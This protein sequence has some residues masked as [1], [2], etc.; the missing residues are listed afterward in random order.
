MATYSSVLVWRIQ[1][2]E[3]PGGLQFMRSQRI[4]HDRVTH[5]CTFLSQWFRVWDFRVWDFWEIPELNPVQS[6]ALSNLTSLYL[7]LLICKTVVSAQ[8]LSRVQLF[9]I[10]WDCSLPGSSV[11]WNFPVKNTGVGCHFPVQVIFLTQGSSPRLLC[12]LRC[13]AHPL[14]LHY[15]WLSW[16]WTKIQVKHLNIVLLLLLSSHCHHHHYHLSDPSS[17]F[18]LCWEHSFCELIL[19]V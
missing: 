18:S 6:L 2:T 12:L 8:W 3:E 15:W 11:H 10:P 4:R 14:P 1:W 16:G 9:A 19:S 5:T 17:Y 7:S 13:Q